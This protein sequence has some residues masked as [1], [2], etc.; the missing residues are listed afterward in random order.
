[1]SGVGNAYTLMSNRLALRTTIPEIDGST[2]V[3]TAERQ[4][5]HG[6]R[7][8][9]Q[10]HNR[11]GQVES[12][13]CERAA[14]CCPSCSS[15]CHVTSEWRGPD[16]G[17]TPRPVSKLPRRLAK[18]PGCF[19]ASCSWQRRPRQGNPTNA[20]ARFH[21]S[22]RSRPPSRAT[23]EPDRHHARLPTTR[24]DRV[25]IANADGSNERP[26]I[27]PADIDYDATWSPDGASDRVHVGAQRLGR[28]VSREADGS[29]L[30]TTHRQ[31]RVRRPSG[32]SL[33]TA[34]NSSSSRRAPAA[35]SDLWTLE[36]ATQ[37]R[38]R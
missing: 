20:H 15:S 29:G 17:R 30:G 6:K 28:S 13:T 21:R 22:R 1:V 26:L 34:S 23:T 25:F 12:Y 27:A 11:P 9:P 19:A 18:R 31:S 4:R 7:R 32:V 8:E 14:T 10:S 38:R 33:P 36:I 37:K 2:S 5:S 24:P 35:R 3:R 16:V